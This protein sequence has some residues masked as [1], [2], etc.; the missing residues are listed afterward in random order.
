VTSSDACAAIRVAVL[1]QWVPSQLADVLALQRAEEP[2]TIA[3]L[4]ECG[5][6]APLADPSWPEFDLAVATKHLRW[7]DWVS[8]PLW[9]GTL[10]VAV[11]KR[12]HLLAFREIPCEELRK[13]PIIRAKAT[14]NEPWHT[15]ASRLLQATPEE[16]DQTVATF[17]L[18]M[19]L[20]AA[21]YG[22]AIAP[23]ARL[24]G[25]QA[26]GIAVRPLA[27]AVPIVTAFLLHRSSSLT[28]PQQRFAARARSV[29]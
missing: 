4:V 18:A 16:H 29:D 24:A 11:A 27:R 12:S 28:E 8:E 10:A 2:E 7:P 25:Y 23:A 21:G 19:T 6:S 13:Q 1:G 5:A 3:A 20:V 17:D 15:E 26:R 14:A 9:H 22:I